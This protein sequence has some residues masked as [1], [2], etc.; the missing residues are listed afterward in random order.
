M[1]TTAALGLLVEHATGRALDQAAQAILFD[2]L[3]RTGVHLTTDG[4]QPSDIEYRL[5][6]DRLSRLG[7]AGTFIVSTNDIAATLASAT[8]DDLATMTWPGV[9]IDQYGWGHT[10]TVDGALA[11]AWVLEGGRTVISTTIAGR[12]PSTGGAVCDQV[13]SAI[14]DDL[15]IGQGLPDR[16]PP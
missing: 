13:V 6:V 10:G 1:A 9:I 5:G 4:Q 2:P 12:S 11:C 8:D 15:G 3:G 7:G 16:S 14:A